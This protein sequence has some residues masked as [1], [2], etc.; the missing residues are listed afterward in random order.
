MPTSWR[1][2]PGPARRIGGAISRAIEAAGGSDRDAY[3]SAAADVASLPPEAAGIVLGAVVRSLLEDQHPDGLDGDDIKVVLAR[4]YGGAITWLPI[5]SVDV[6]PLLAVLAS[7]LGIHEP[8]V[9]YHEITGPPPAAHGDDWSGDPDVASIGATETVDDPLKVRPPT[10]AEYAWH[11]P[12]LIADLLAVSGRPLGR[13]LDA[14]FAEIAR[15][16][17]MEMP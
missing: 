13:Y 9:T 2:L 5:E 12:L 6:H 4:C 8:G 7:A 1:E 11:A 3:D 17:T 14:A 15:G 10:A 16:E